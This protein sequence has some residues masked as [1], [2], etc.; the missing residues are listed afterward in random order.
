[1]WWAPAG[2]VIIGLVQLVPL[3]LSVPAI[4]SPGTID[5]PRC[6]I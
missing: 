5:Y 2:I 1:M 4:V 3:P 6:P